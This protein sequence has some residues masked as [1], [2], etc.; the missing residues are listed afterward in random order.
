M[1]QVTWSPSAKR[2]LHALHDAIAE[3]SPFYA[4]RFVERLAERVLFLGDH[5][6]A[7]H[8]VK[9]FNDKTIREISFGSYRIIHKLTAGEVQI[10]RVFHGKR[11]LR[12][13]DIDE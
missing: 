10:V 3:D 7:G 2:D 12:G 11:M 8:I 9:E 1:A 6:M 13:R 4:R 5:P